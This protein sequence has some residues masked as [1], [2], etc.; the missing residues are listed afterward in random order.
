MDLRFDFEKER[1]EYLGLT[2]KDTKKIYNTIIECYKE[3]LIKAPR[4]TLNFV[5]DIVLCN[6]NYYNKLGDLKKL[7]E[8][9]GD[10]NFYIDINRS[11]FMEQV[12]D[13]EGNIE[14]GDDDLYFKDIMDTKNIEDISFSLKE[15]IELCK[16]DDFY[17]R[18]YAQDKDDYETT[19]EIRPNKPFDMHSSIKQYLE[20]IK[21]EG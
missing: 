7:N 11:G 10:N 8:I 15:L 16:K 3:K 6:M 1:K 21:R 12:I 20:T 18:I 9:W 14:Y 19:V 17:I 2:R 4:K 5:I 13:E